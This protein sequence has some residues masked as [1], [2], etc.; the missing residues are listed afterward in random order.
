MRILELQEYAK[1][2]GY[3]SLEFTMT[4]PIST[5]KKG[6]WLDA[7][8]GFFWIEG[9]KENEMMTVSQLRE[10]FGDELFEFKPITNNQ[11]TT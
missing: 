1:E 8:Y 11:Q 4:S 5:L 6:K 9:M 3:S 7:Y 10:E 2:H